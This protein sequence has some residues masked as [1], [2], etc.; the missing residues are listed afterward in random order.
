MLQQ[1]LLVKKKIRNDFGSVRRPITCT[2]TILTQIPHS[3][4]FFKLFPNGGYVT[5]LSLLCIKIDYHQ[6]GIF[7]IK[8]NI[9]W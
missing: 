7:P 9:N 3:V 5:F 4:Y 8:K 2:C 6:K 1:K